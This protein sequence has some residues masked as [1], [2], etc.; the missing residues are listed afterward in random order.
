MT[1]VSSELPDLGSRRAGPFERAV[2][3]GVVVIATGGPI[4]VI[5]SAFGGIASR[6]DSNP[7]TVA[8]WV[9][10]YVGASWIAFRGARDRFLRAALGDRLTLGL[11]ALALVSTAWSADPALT[12]KRGVALLGTCVVGWYFASRYDID[13]LLD[14][15]ATGFLAAAVLSVLFAVAI[16]ALGIQPP[17][18]SLDESVIDTDPYAGAW[19]GIYT[20]KNLLAQVMGIGA[21]TMALAASRPGWRRALYGGGALAAVAVIVMTRSASGLG[22][23]AA[24]FVVAGLLRGLRTH[25]YLLAAGASV[26]L[27]GTVVGGWA[28]YANRGLL[29][30]SLG[31]DPTLTGRT[32]LWDAVLDQFATRPWFGWGHEAF[33]REWQGVGSNRVYE[34][35]AWTPGYSHN[36]FLDQ[37]VNLGVVG[38]AVL[39]A[40]L[41][42]NVFLALR[43]AR[44]D[45]RPAALWACVV[46]AFLLFA[47]G[48]EGGLVQQN[49]YMWLLFIAVSTS[50]RLAGTHAL[51]AAPAWVLTRM[52]S[53]PGRRSEWVGSV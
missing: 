53:A 24:L 33:W 17:D 36:G 35:T 28:V 43:H 46:F 50:V 30:D 48:T 47:N 7:A 31:R 25:R 22:L 9:A 4:P 38:L 42:T 45:R 11:V 8:L 52:S 13:E 40:A 23:C 41:A 16:P 19:R 39:V 21:V 51:V 5:Q 2:A 3:A 32:V 29:F 6:V 27:L 14:V 15:V 12:L 26:G 10:F 49:G 20:T 1:R 37:L 34:I 18:A 44:R